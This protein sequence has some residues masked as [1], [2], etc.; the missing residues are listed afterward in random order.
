MNRVTAAICL[1]L[2]TV[3][4]IEFGLLGAS[5]AG[6]TGGNDNDL[7]PVGDRL[8]VVPT[9]TPTVPPNPSPTRLT[10]VINPSSPQLSPPSV[11][12]GITIIADPLAIQCDGSQTSH[13]RVRI[14]D[15]NGKTAPDGINVYFE[16][17][18]GNTEPYFAQTV[19]GYADT[20]VRFLRRHLPVRPQ[21]A[22][23]CRPA[24]RWH[25]HPMFPAVRR[26]HPDH[27]TL[28]PAMRP[29]TNADSI[30]PAGM[31]PDNSAIEPAVRPSYAHQP[32]G[33]RSVCADH[34][35]MRHT[36]TLHP[37]RRMFAVAACGQSA[38]RPTIS[39][40][41]PI[42][43]VFDCDLAEPG[44]QQQCSA[45]RGS[46]ID[47]GVVLRNRYGF[48]VSLA[49]FNFFAVNDSIDRLLPPQLGDGNLNANPDFNQAA[50]TGA[51]WACTPPPPTP[52][53]VPGGPDTSSLLSCFTG[54]QNGP[55]IPDG[56]T[57]LLGTVRYTVPADAPLGTAN[58]SFVDTA[59]F[60]NTFSEIGSCNPVVTTSMSCGIASIEI[61]APATAT[62]TRTATPV[63][64][65]TMTP[66][67]T[68]Q[69][70]RC[71]DITGNGRVNLN[72]VKEIARAVIEGHYRA[73]YD[74]N[75]DG[76]LSYADVSAAAKQL[77]M[78]C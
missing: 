56:A 1:I 60:D 8:G 3:A 54:L 78:R 41:A 10:P 39:P 4:A 26:V 30:Q 45:A 31:H 6:I 53:W 25:P 46:T 68:P 40:P 36:D 59:A 61:T 23:A 27:S 34:T 73:A 55:T 35:T 2:V 44:E 7:P 49:A 42:D 75:R 74:I 66:T 76:T 70:D 67:T 58:L 50:V 77:G 15:I 72:D 24:A 64:T 19:D 43:I 38:V 20:D 28:Q 69:P 18:N 51:G 57:I 17:Y 13:V 14:L 11:V 63:Q 5:A 29:D 65:V 37:A 33:L 12:S 52:D 48:P 62:A 9:D 47:V 71:A 21:P 32:A 22:R 16:A